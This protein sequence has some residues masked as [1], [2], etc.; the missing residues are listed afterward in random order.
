MSWNYNYLDAG[1]ALGVDLCTNPELVANDGAVA[2]GSAIWFW[3][4]QGATTAHDSIEVDSDFGGT[5]KAINGGNECPAQ[6]ESDFAN[7]VVQRLDKY[8]EAATQLD[9]I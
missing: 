5:V 4:T 8:C 7:S 6:S 1:T 2:W 3:M 9:V